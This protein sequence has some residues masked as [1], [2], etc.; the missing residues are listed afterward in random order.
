P[1]RMTAIRPLQP[2]VG[3]DKTLEVDHRDSTLSW[4]NLTFTSSEDGNT[5]TGQAPFDGEGATML[6]VH[7]A[8]DGTDQGAS[9]QGHTITSF[10]EALRGKDSPLKPADNTPCITFGEE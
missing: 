4:I 3:G 2:T 5:F 8:L 7:H 6:G 9:I 1:V 10:K